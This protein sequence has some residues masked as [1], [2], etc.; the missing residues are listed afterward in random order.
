MKDRDISKSI[1]D[2]QLGDVSGG[3]GENVTNRDKSFLGAVKN[4]FGFGKKEDLRKGNFLDEHG[5]YHINCMKCGKKIKSWKPSPNSCYA[6]GPQVCMDCRT[7]QKNDHL[8]K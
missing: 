6:C 1:S 3:L 4:F 7:K 5:V 8:E 2:E